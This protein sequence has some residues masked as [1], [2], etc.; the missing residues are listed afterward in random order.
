MRAE[1]KIYSDA[2]E[3]AYQSAPLQ[4][5]PGEPEI[6]A[7]FLNGGLPPSDDCVIQW[8]RFCAGVRSLA[9]F[10]PLLPAKHNGDA[11]Q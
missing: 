7:I 11:P 9:D 5:K 4:L 3:L 2:G 8:F 6:G 1:I 10:K